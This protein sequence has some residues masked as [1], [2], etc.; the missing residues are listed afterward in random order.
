[1]ALIAKPSP[2]GSVPGGGA[3]GRDVE[4]FFNLGGQGLDCVFSSFSRVL[5]VISEGLVVI[6]ISYWVLVVTCM[7]TVLMQL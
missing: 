4:N 3:G 2:S 6:S 5:L 1:V 7:S